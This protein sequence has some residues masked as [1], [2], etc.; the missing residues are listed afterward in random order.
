MRHPKNFVRPR[1]PSFIV[2]CHNRATRIPEF[3]LTSA[4][5]GPNDPGILRLNTYSV[6]VGGFLDY[7]TIDNTRPTSN[8]GLVRQTG[9]LSVKADGPYN[10]NSWAKRLYCGGANSDSF[11]F[12]VWALDLSNPKVV[13]TDG[14]FYGLFRIDS[15]VEWKESDTTI[16][17]G[18]I[19]YVL[20]LD[21]KVNTY[22]DNSV[23]ALVS[24]DLEV[25]TSLPIYVGNY[26]RVK[27]Y[28]RQA[29]SNLSAIGSGSILA[30]FKGKI[31]TVGGSINLGAST[32]LAGNVGNVIKIRVEETLEIISGTVIDNLDGTYSIGTLTHDDLWDTLTFD[33]YKKNGP[34]IDAAFNPAAIQIAEAATRVPYDGMYFVVPTLNFFTNPGSAAVANKVCRMSSSVDATNRVWSVDPITDPGYPLYRTNVGIDYAGAPTNAAFTATPDAHFNYGVASAAQSCAIYFRNVAATLTAVAPGMTWVV[35]VTNTVNN[36]NASILTNSEYYVRTLGAAIPNGGV[37]CVVAGNVRPVPSNAYTILYNQTFNG[38]DKL[39]KISVIVDLAITFR[40]ADGSGNITNGDVDKSFLLVNLEQSIKID[41]FVKIVINNLAPLES[42][43]LSY[44]IR[45]PDPNFGGPGVCAI[46]GE[47]DSISSILD[48][49]LYEAGH[50]IKWIVDGP[51]KNLSIYV[52]DYISK[53]F[54]FIYWTDGVKLFARPLVN[55]DITDFD[56]IE[57]SSSISLGKLDTQLITGAE[58]GEYTN[59]WFKVTY[60]NDIYSNASVSLRS[61][62]ARGKKDRYQE[63]KFNH[64][65]DVVSAEDAIRRMS[66]A[67][68]FA[69]FTDIMRKFSMRV[70]L[71]KANLEAGDIVNL[72]NLKHVSE[73]ALPPLYKTDSG[74]YYFEYTYANP[75][76]ILPNIAVV[77][78]VTSQVDSGQ[79]YVSIEL[80]QVQLQIRDNITFLT[81]IDSV[82]PPFTPGEVEPINPGDPSAID[83]P[84]LTKVGPFPTVCE[85]PPIYP[86]PTTPPTPSNTSTPC[87]SAALECNPGGDA[88]PVIDSSRYK[89]P[90][91]YGVC[92][93]PPRDFSAMV[94]AYFKEASIEITGSSVSAIA[95]YDLMAI[96]GSGQSVG[97]SA[98]ANFPVISATIAGRK[99]V[100]PN[101]GLSGGGVPTKSGAPLIT[102]AISAGLWL[103]SEKGLTL[104][105]DVWF[106]YSYVA[107][108]NNGEVVTWPASC[109]CTIKPG[110]LLAITCEAQQT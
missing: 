90:I 94:L 43:I 71:D 15:G 16:T 64:V 59:T 20:S 107:N 13:I 4:S 1:K 36:A 99:F 32:F 74:D 75:Y 19:D 78:K 68:H 81:N 93:V 89:D 91:Y 101:S 70:R 72:R 2:V 55:V 47:N 61:T 3:Y 63:F 88:A 5:L 54:R 67:A 76:V 28:G 44:A 39:T 53:N 52:D 17:V 9:S 21:D 51:T 38:I 23:A 41:E 49:A 106:E 40:T 6:P 57:D 96:I 109:S 104:N 50:T 56:I 80:K 100:P 48:S 35:L 37:F 87:K 85:S 82:T 22:S 65:S 95:L 86:P 26:S 98:S 24:T 79:C 14:M 92:T 108:L 11:Y 83:N 62:L 102:A 103:D 45:V 66:K 46:I 33:G 97:F 42:D 25:L 29:L 77:D 60:S 58:Q 69:G 7:V 27:A 31:S 110:K 12:S 84:D 10:K 8:G 73:E 18:I 30:Q 105:I 34:P